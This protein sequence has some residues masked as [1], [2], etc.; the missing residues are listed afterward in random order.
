MRV[1]EAHLPDNV[2][3]LTGEAR[4][5]DSCRVVPLA[6]VSGRSGVERKRFHLARELGRRALETASGQAADRFPAAFL[7]P[8]G[9]Q[10]RDVGPR[11]TGFGVPELMRLKRLCG[12]P[13]AALLVC[14]GQVGVPS[15]AAVDRAFRTYARPWPV[16]QAEPIGLDDRLAREERPQRFERLVWRAVG[17]D[18]IAP[19]RAAQLLDRPLAEVEADLRGYAA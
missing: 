4:L 11:R 3:A 10:R 9:R 6:L 17:E 13:A 5:S 7:T 8:G 16:E 12:V 1:I 15:R 18:L 19:I 14:L 2:H